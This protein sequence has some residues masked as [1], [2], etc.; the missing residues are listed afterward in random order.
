MIRLNW[1]KSKYIISFLFGVFLASVFVIIT[2]QYRTIQNCLLNRELLKQIP[3]MNI[4]KKQLF[5]RILSKRTKWLFLFCVFSFTP[6]RHKMFHIFYGMLGYGMG[7][8][9]SLSFAQYGWF[10]IWVALG[11][12]I[13]QVFFLIPAYIGTVKLFIEGR[14][15]HAIL[16]KVIKCILLLL[17]GIYCE[18]YVNLY[19]VSFILK[20]I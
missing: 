17:I 10:G 19:V 6:I 1:S 4:Q 14:G 11:A 20:F 5:L 9:L 13:P 12:V 8:L 16:I 2:C 3:Y 7:A 15:Q 18:C